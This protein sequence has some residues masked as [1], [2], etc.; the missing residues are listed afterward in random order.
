MQDMSRDFADY[1]PGD[2]YWDVFAFDVYDRGFDKSWYDYILP[3]VGDKPMAIGECDKLPSAKMLDEQPRW[4][5]FMSWAELT[6]E[7]NSDADI[8]A[9]FNSPRMVHQRDL[10]DFRKR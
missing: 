7:K 9:L 4:C 1:N 3:I 8:R 6:F 10:P 5:F 2:K